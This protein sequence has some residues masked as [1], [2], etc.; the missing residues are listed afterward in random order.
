MNIPAPEKL[1]TSE[2]YLYAL[3]SAIIDYGYVPTRAIIPS[4]A[5]L[6]TYGYYRDVFGEEKAQN[7]I[8]L[9]ASRRN[10]SEADKWQLLDWHNH[11]I[12]YSRLWARVKK[13]A[14]R[15]S[16]DNRQRLQEYLKEMNGNT[17]GVMAIIEKECALVGHARREYLKRTATRLV[18]EV[19]GGQRPYNPH[20]LK[21]T[22]GKNPE[23]VRLLANSSRL[24]K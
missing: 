3:K 6:L 17:T 8:G 15:E 2:N 18:W 7:M 12:W 20:Q 1:P 13:E 10:M 22:A 24:D 9:A 4:S 19:W 14:G 21:F 11:P 5:T 23:I 16:A